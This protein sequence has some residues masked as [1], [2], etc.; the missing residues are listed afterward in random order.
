MQCNKFGKYLAL[1]DEL[2][3][4]DLKK[5]LEEH[6]SACPVCRVRLEE[7]RNVR[8]DLRAWKRVDIP[9]LVAANL[10]HAVLN[11]LVSG[12]NQG[13][14]LS[15]SRR[16]W[17]QFRIMPYAVGTVATFLLVFLLLS[18]MTIGYRT[19]EGDLAF[20]DV[21]SSRKTIMIAANRLPQDQMIET[22]QRQYALSRIGFAAESPSLNPSGTLLTVTNS[23]MRGK[24]KSDEVV[25]VAD[26]LSN[27][28]A[29][30]TEIVESPTN[31]E[32]LIAI[33]NALQTDPDS[34]PFVPARFDGR[35]DVVRI[36]L[37]IQ[38]VD[39]HPRALRS[40]STRNRR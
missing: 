33:E 9:D 11:E 27:G 8:A 6:L 39:V 19:A 25:F 18:T 2:T 36:V 28:M 22:S 38:R 12:A 26:V 3:D 40:S 37:K 13:A 31:A 20:S 1:Y 29:K 14:Y 4:E 30:V 17:L 10:R 7:L 15:N 16:E 24:M 32:D 34:S 5:S 23:L 35:S 21:D